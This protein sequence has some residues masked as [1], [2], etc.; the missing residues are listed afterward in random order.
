MKAPPGVELRAIESFLEMLAAERNAAALTLK[1]YRADLVDF[2]AFLA[3]RR[4]VAHEAATVDVAAYL[5]FLTQRGASP[6]TQARR[7]S[8][9]R[10][11]H[12]FLVLEKRRL[13]DPTQTIDGPRLGRA[14]PKV[15]GEGEVGALLQAARALEGH[16]GVRLVALIEL[17]YS[18]GLRVSELVSLRLGAIARDRKT[19]LIR[20]KGG[21]E[22]LA[23]LGVPA[24][25]AIAAWLET[26]KSLAPKDQPSPFVF[27]SRGAAGHITAARVAQLLKDVAARAGID[28]RR[29][30]PHVLRHAFAT[31]LVDHGAD[32]RAVQQMLGHADIATTQ[33]YTHVAGE[34][35]KRVVS[36]HHPLT[37]GRPGR[38]RK[39]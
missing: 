5:K 17:L 6:R 38:P 20:G 3:R 28:P 12:R 11:F 14:L 8:A 35:L 36:E 13:D 9:L 2:A 7:L 30:S 10:Q 26:R 29:V 22:R 32:L 16:D 1:A 18:A 33:I 27:A 37:S 24:R 19:L 31:H 39:S 4:I 34:R 23:P 25:D 21:K 15:L